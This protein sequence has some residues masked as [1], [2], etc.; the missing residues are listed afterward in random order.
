MPYYI[1]GHSIVGHAH[2]ESM[3]VCRE[4]HKWIDLGNEWVIAAVADGV[5]ARL[6][7]NTAV[8]FMARYMPVSL[9]EVGVLRAIYLA[10][11]A[12]L[13]EIQRQSVCD[14]VSLDSF[15][16][17]LLL[18]A[19]NGEN[20]CYGRVGDGAIFG[21]TTKGNYA[22]ITTRNTAASPLVAGDDTWVIESLD[23]KHRLSSVLLVTD[24]VRSALKP[25]ELGGIPRDIYVPICSLLMHPAL[26]RRYPQDYQRIVKDYLS[27]KLGSN[28]VYHL[29]SEVYAQAL[30]SASPVEQTVRSVV[31]SGYVDKLMR[32]IQDDKTVLAIV[33]T[34]D[35]RV[36]DR[37][38]AQYYWEPTWTEEKPKADVGRTV[39]APLSAG[40][41]PP[42]W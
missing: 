31:Q 25:H 3:T 2:T 26:C 30:T 19:Y 40:A 6:A 21:L 28:D 7:V 35:D 29:L 37:V 4:T 39:F 5:G 16:C 38:D 22:E 8:D 41:V 27:C 36:P 32:R 20:L 23:E 42:A 18:A 14:R 15:D 17:T 11:N 12:A 13:I 33:N 34:G 9:W 10:F 1:Y 24:G